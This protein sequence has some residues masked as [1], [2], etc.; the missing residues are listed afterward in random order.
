MVERVARKLRELTKANGGVCRGNDETGW[1]D[2]VGDARQII[3]TMRRPSMAMNDA[4][5]DIGDEALHPSRDRAQSESVWQ[6][7]IDAALTPN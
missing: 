4:V 5:F 7:M 1:N 3:A 2:Y 6:T